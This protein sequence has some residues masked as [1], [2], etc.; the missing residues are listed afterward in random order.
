[1]AGCSKKQYAIMMNSNE[2]KKLAAKM[3][4]MEQEEFNK[5]F[6]DLLGSN[7]NQDEDED[8]E[9]FDAES[10]EDFE[11]DE[12]EIPTISEIE[13]W[14]KDNWSV[15]EKDPSTGKVLLPN[16]E[17]KRQLE[18]ELNIT[19]ED[20]EWDEIVE[21]VYGE[22]KDEDD[23]FGPVEQF[24]EAL[25]DAK[26]PEDKEELVKSIDKQLN[27]GEITEQEASEMKEL[28]DAESEE[29]LSL[30]KKMSDFKSVDEY[31]EW[32]KSLSDEEQKIH[33]LGKK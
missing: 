3:G 8:Y 5:A 27:N 7:Y 16:E 17:D 20:E 10:D 22:Y 12:D 23:D 9:E 30:N 21:N 19:L 24:K 31:F 26:T 6:S 11:T 13:D 29:N 4:G 33:L 1:M 28:L 32:F 15:G 18:E 25:A 14:I 2:G